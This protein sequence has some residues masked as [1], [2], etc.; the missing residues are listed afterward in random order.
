MEKTLM[1]MITPGGRPGTSLENPP[2]TEVGLT[3]SGGGQPLFE[4]N[5]S[6]G[7]L[8]SSRVA[9]TI[10]TTNAESVLTDALQKQGKQ[11]SSKPVGNQTEPQE[12]NY[13]SEWQREIK[14]RKALEHTI[15]KL[16]Q[17]IMDLEK[18]VTLLSTEDKEN[19]SLLNIASKEII[20]FTDEEELSRETDWILK[21]RKRPNKKRKALSSP[22]TP[23]PNQSKG[24][25]TLKQ[26]DAEN[27]PRKNGTLKRQHLPPPIIVSG[28]ETFGV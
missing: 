11:G 7:N 2:S 3:D 4:V 19:T 18:K 10:T 16:Q 6:S 21:E 24:T 22:D 8:L 20:Y 25:A 28:I 5:P 14:A 13:Y 23:L 9:C 17:H 12:L 26:V 27:M 15:E 1:E